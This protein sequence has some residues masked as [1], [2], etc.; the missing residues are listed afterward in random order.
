[1][2]EH[3]DYFKLTSRDIYSSLKGFVDKLNYLTAEFKKEAVQLSPAVIKFL[4][5]LL[6]QPEIIAKALKK[7]PMQDNVLAI[8]LPAKN[9]QIVIEISD[10]EKIFDF[11]QINRFILEKTK[12]FDALKQIKEKI[13]NNIELVKQSEYFASNDKKFK[14]LLVI[15]DKLNEISSDYEK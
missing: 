13:D 1:M 2:K 4:A 14:C 8:K 5:Q 9:C 3:H 11:E 7:G 15:F 10:L 12:D 6:Y